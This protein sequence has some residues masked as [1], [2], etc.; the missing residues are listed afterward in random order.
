M[1]RLQTKSIKTDQKIKNLI[2]SLGLTPGLKGF[3]CLEEAIKI[4]LDEGQFFPYDQVYPQIY[5]RCNT[6]FRAKVHSEN[7]TER[8]KEKYM[9]AYRGVKNAINAIWCN[10]DNEELLNQ[11]FVNT[12]YYPSNAIFIEAVAR[13]VCYMD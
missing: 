6:K 2:R 8:N 7:P 10:P 12:D 3:Y 1:T 4:T 11:I 9:I 13:Y 5:D